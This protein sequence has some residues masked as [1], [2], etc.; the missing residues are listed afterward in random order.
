MTFPQKA[1]S[2]PTALLEAGESGTLAAIVFNLGLIWPFLGR[3]GTKN[4]PSEEKRGQ[5]NRARAKMWLSGGEQG[6]PGPVQAVPASWH[7]FWARFPS[8]ERFRSETFSWQG[9]LHMR[10]AVSAQPPK[11]APGLGS[12]PKSYG[13]TL[14]R[15][16]APSPSKLPLTF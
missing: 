13:A 8:A 6:K 10:S 5:K 4:A 12:H 7:C 11:A 3:S 9:S 14:C 15:S 1:V 2:M 16:A